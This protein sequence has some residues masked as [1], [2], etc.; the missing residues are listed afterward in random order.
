MSGRVTAGTI[1]AGKYRLISLLGRGGMGS[2]WRAERLGWQAPVAI[3]VM[4]AADEDD[5]RARDRFVRESRL[6]ASLR[7]VH[8]VQVLDDGIDDDTGNPFMVMELL[9][10]ETLAERLH[11]VKHL[12]APIVAQIISQIARA[13]ARAHDAGLVHRDMK[14][15]NILIVRNDDEEVIK[16]LDFGIAKSLDSPQKQVHRTH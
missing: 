16:V 5:E 11:R 13:L 15:D 4:N 8:V 6:I 14:P 10:G 7:S 1:L 3:K 9:E 12:R 2:V